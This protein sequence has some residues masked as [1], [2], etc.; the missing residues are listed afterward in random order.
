[1]VP[2]VELVMAGCLLQR[3]SELERTPWLIYTHTILE[4]ELRGKET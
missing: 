4:Q 1:M 2:V 3:V